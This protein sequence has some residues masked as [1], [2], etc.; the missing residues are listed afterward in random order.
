MQIGVVVVRART[1]VEQTVKKKVRQLTYWK[2][3]IVA[4][5][6]LKGGHS[7]HVSVAG[8]VLLGGEKRFFE[9]EHGEV[10]F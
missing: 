5:A 8:E 3:I 7:N 1:G 2:V 10:S 4:V 9:C 6:L